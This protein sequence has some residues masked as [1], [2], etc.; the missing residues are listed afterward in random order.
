MAVSGIA[1][2]A[3]CGG[4]PPATAAA[5]SGDTAYRTLATEILEDFYKRNPTHATDLG[6]HKYDAELDDYSAEA[7]TAEAQA[8]KAFKTRLQAVDP[9][10]LALDAQLDREELL[11]VMDSI[12]LGD[13]VIRMWAKDPDRYASGL[14]NTAYVMIKR[15][16]APA[17]ERMRLLIARE[18]KMPA[19]LA[20]ARKNLD[21]PPRIYTEIAIEQI[22]G[23]IGFFKS[24]VPEAFAGVKDAALTAEFKKANDA[25]IA[26]LTGYKD[27]LKK[28]LLARSNGTFAYGADTYRKRFLADEMIDT[29]L[30]QLLAIA[31]RD[32]KKNQ[33]AFE[34]TAK[35]IDPKKTARQV[36]DALQQDHPPAEKLLATTQSELDALAKFLTDHKIVTIPNAAPARVKETPPFMRATTSASMDIPGPFEPSASEAYYNMTLPEPAWSLTERGEFMKQWYYAAIT[37][38]SVHEVWPGHYLQFLYAKTYPSDVRKVFGAA[39]NSEGWAHYSE[40]MVLDEGFHVDEPRYRLAQIQDALLRNVRFIV[41]IKMHTEGMTPAQAEEMFVKDGYQPLPVA[42]SE[43]KRGTSDAT[44]GYYTMGKLMILKLRDDYKNKVGASFL[45][46]DFHDRFIKMGPLPL[47]LI[48]RAML[49]EVGSL[50]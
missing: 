17:E 1:L 39:T 21:N 3:S 31:D 26:A 27:W 37:N 30:D 23:N 49:G 29:P 43:T 50:F 40:Q 44:Y 36:L 47:P 33:A 4:N 24:A 34:D 16:F 28:D 41:G 42:K 46:Q 22:D 2:W 18:Q 8:A 45:L 6:I 15:S 32:L 7:V 10:T 12:V 20:N 9:A 38:V 13:E 35:K 19:A 11:H 48:R 5:G 25:V 14:T